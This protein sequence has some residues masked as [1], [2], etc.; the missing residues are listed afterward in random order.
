MGVKVEYRGSLGTVLHNKFVKEL[1]GMLVGDYADYK[2]VIDV[3]GLPKKA[4]EEALFYPVVLSDK[5]KE[6]SCPVPF[7]DF[8]LSEEAYYNTKAMVSI[9]VVMWYIS[10]KHVPADR[11]GDLVNDPL[12]DKPNKELLFKYMKR[13]AFVVDEGDKERCDK[14]KALLK[15]LEDIVDGGEK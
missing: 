4:L 5:R 3:G 12:M 10:V 13:L 2:V 6:I 8:H 1:E 15:A 9:L 11:L 14:E 7:G